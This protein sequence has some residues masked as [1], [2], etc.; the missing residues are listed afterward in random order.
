MILIAGINGA[1]KT[2]F[3]YNHIKPWL[4]NK[5]IVIP[6]VNADELEKAK[7]PSAVGQHSLE[8]AKLAAQIRAEYLQTGQ[9]FVTETVFSHPSKNQLITE[10]QQAGFKVIL[11]HVHVAAPD[12]ALLRVQ[13]RV[14]RGG[15]SVPKEKIFSRFERTLNYIATATKVADLTYVWDNSSSSA[16]STSKFYFV[17][18]L[19]KG[20][21][22]RL[23]ENIPDWVNHVY[24]Q[25][26][27]IYRDT[28]K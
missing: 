18:T 11:N 13:T 17:M 27:E 14:T 15:H 4:D 22:I 7:F 19:A 20:K 1:G 10:A 12:L 25:Q 16:F 28:L 8:M 26:I 3:Y 21:V 24:Q 5:N 23:A 6:F 9:S 2:T